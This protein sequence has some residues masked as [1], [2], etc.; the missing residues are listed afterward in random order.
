MYLGCA[1]SLINDLT[2]LLVFS[3]VFADQTRSSFGSGNA[4]KTRPPVSPG[5]DEAGERITHKTRDAGASCGA[6][7]MI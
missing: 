3:R 2:R 5:H 4:L 6:G 7:S 1:Y